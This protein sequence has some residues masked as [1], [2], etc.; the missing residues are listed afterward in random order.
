M[1]VATRDNRLQAEVEKIENWW[2]SEKQ[3]RLQRPYSALDVAR[4]RNSIELNHHVSSQQA[5]KLWK[6]FEEKVAKQEPLLTYGAVDPILLSQLSKAGLEIGYVSG[7]VCGFSNVAEPSMDT[8]DY[9]WDTVPN[10]VQK[11]V[12][13][14][15]W[16]DRRQ[17]HLRSLMTPEE[18]AVT[19][20]IDYL[21]PLIADGD[22]GFGSTT[23]IMK[24]TKKFV[25][26]GVAMF[27][28][29]DLAIGMKRFTIGEGRTVV[30][31]CEYLKRLTA[32]RF[33]LDLMGA[34][35]LLMGRADS[36]H[37][38]YITSVI[39]P[40][41]HGYVQGV[42]NPECEPLLATMVKAQRE[43]RD[44]KSTR[45][46]W[47]EKAGLMTFDEAVQQVATP[48]EYAAYMAL[49]KNSKF[50][51]ITERRAHAAKTVSKPVF[52]DW[53][54]AR[55]TDGQY[56]FKHTLE[57]VIDRAIAALPVTDTTWARMDAPK[58]GEIVE[59]HEKLRAID[60]RRAYGFGYTGR[61]D[62][63]AAGFTEEQFKNLHW[64]LAKLGI[65]FQT[66]PIYACQGLNMVSLEFGK[67]FKKEGIYG[68]DRDI[69]QFCKKNN[70]DGFET[71]WCGAKLSDDQMF[72][73]DSLDV[74]LPF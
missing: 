2:K 17:N 52:F 19:P 36:L 3:S 7:A 48:E 28:L 1:T 74:T 54:A 25:E 53:E 56:F 21:V 66:Q 35:T 44:Y 32:A 41:D 62:Y 72:A 63:Y 39:D 14:Q 16:H 10:T 23:G 71:S 67:M 13:S 12:N 30:P 38:E 50:K 58:W 15:L 73:A 26:A 40:R 43:G 27:H 11:L 60:N 47:L 42:T 9:P 70:T 4:M 33:Q 49:F 24:L 8:A 18:L 55:S 22:M 31:T 68:Y 51:S 64:E 45:K 57:H 59:F 6:L 69:I 65:V 46:A 20:E 5:I 34:E 29:D 61:Y 37:A